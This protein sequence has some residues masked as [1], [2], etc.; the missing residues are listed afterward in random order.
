[1]ASTN[2]I[3]LSKQY[4]NANIQVISE[5]VERDYDVS[6]VDAYFVPSS[7]SNTHITVPLDFTFDNIANV[8]V[9]S[10]ETGD[11]YQYNLTPL[12]DEQKIIKLN[13]TRATFNRARFETINSIQWKYDKYNR[14]V[15]LGLTPKE[16]INKLDA[17]CQAW[18][19]IPSQ[20]NFPWMITYPIPD[21]SANTAN[22][23]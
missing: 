23:W 21:F 8:A 7:N 1:M 2:L 11:I 10:T 20:N 18:L 3:I 12:T 14:E 4:P 19:D 17:F 13:V 6:F 15:R 16:D 9:V 5:F 22:T